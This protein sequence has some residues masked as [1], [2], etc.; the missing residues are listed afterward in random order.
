MHRKLS[1]Q[2][3]R[4][5]CPLAF[6]LFLMIMIL[7]S[8]CATF[9]EKE[10]SA[11]AREG[12]N[13]K[14]SL[15]L[16]RSMFFG[17]SHYFI[18][19]GQPLKSFGKSNTCPNGRVSI[20]LGQGILRQV[21][22]LKEACQ[23][24][25]DAL[26]YL[27]N[28]LGASGFSVRLDVIPIDTSHQL[29]EFIVSRKPKMMLGVAEFDS[30]TR[31]LHN[32][33]DLIAHEGYHTVNF[34]HGRLDIGADERSAYYFGLCAQLTILGQISLEDLPGVA[35]ENN[36]ASSRAAENVRIRV[37]DLMSEDR[38]ILAGTKEAELILMECNI[39]L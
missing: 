17:R 8:G 13:A 31:T 10:W 34:W 4:A 3:K 12:V 29:Q 36:N 14:K 9:N 39:S 33:V 20:R 1:E 11:L 38:E 26:S 32:M 21:D 24:A 18:P 37:V 2:G 6:H 28:A 16:G 25:S 15:R 5:S 23:V 19:G 7:L 30:R 35:L 22:F 27:D